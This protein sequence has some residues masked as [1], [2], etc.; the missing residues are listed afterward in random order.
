MAASQ[1]TVPPLYRVNG[2]TVPSGASQVVNDKDWG[3][4]RSS[5][6]QTLRLCLTFCQYH[7]HTLKQAEAKKGE[8]LEYAYII[9]MWYV[10]I[11]CCMAVVLI[12]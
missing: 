2:K 11:F 8:K 6:P 5:E 1:V 7:S 4:V 9:G 10:D 3:Y 12:S